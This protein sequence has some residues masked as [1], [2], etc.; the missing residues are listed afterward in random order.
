MARCCPVCIRAWI[1]NTTEPVFR[2]LLEAWVIVGIQLAAI[3]V[4]AL[5]GARKPAQYLALIPVIV[6]TELVDGVWDVYSITYSFE[7]TSMGVTTLIIHGLIFVGAYW[8]W[9][10]A[11][12]DLKAE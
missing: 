6:M 12:L 4:V 8:A 2:L 7:A 5:W 1:S 10:A 11:Q 3:G 9:C